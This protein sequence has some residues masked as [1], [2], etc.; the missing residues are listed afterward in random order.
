GPSGMRP[1]LL[2]LVLLYAG[3]GML[4]SRTAAGS[5]SALPWKRIGAIAVPPQEISMRNKG[6]RFFPGAGAAQVRRNRERVNGVVCN[7]LRSAGR[8]WRKRILIRRHRGQAA[9]FTGL[10]TAAGQQAA[11]RKIWS[12]KRKHPATTG[13]AGC[14]SEDTDA[15]LRVRIHSASWVASSSV[16][17]FGGMGIGPQTPVEPFLM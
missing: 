17:A 14:F 6:L 11:Q 15:Y 16:T 3:V 7:F 10:S 2:R 5:G 12:R 13:P 9:L 8:I 1:G 4:L